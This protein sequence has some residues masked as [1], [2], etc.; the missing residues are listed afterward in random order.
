M[1]INKIMM[2]PVTIFNNFSHSR[3][4]VDVL[5][6]VVIDVLTDVMIGVGVDMLD[7]GVNVNVLTTAMTSLFGMPVRL[8]ESMILC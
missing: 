3:V 7:D 5:T 6:D 2:Q 1:L 8:E 4:V